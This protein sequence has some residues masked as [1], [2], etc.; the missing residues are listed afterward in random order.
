MLGV[1]L[2]H[3]QDPALGLIEFH[4][5]C[6]GPP[7]KVP[8]DG[9]PSLQRVNSTAQLGVIAKLADGALSP[10]VHVA[11]KDVKQH[12]AQYQPLGNTTGCRTFIFSLE[13]H[14]YV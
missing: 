3:V 11:D 12:S 14:S 2:T 4:K 9:I 1:A 5:V 6:T 8:L 7:L 13:T 10:T